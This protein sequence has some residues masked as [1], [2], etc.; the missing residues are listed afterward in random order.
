M[1][2]AKTTVKL[3]NEKG[4]VSI[5][6][7]SAVI[8]MITFIAF[9]VNIGI[10]VKAKI[11]LQ[12]AT[13][14]A[15]YAGASVQ[16]RQLTNIAYMNW[17]MRNVFK[18]WMFKY[19]VLGGL[20]L[21]SVHG[22]ESDTSMHFTMD[23]YT[24]TSSPAVDYYNFPSVCIDFAETG[25]IGMCTKYVVPG[26]PRFESSNVLGMD[27]TTNAF[28]DAIV[29]QKQLN[30]SQ[31]SNVNF[32]TASTWA[33]NVL[34]N[35]A[36]QRTLAQQAPQMATDAMGAF[37][38]AFELG[39]RIRSL[40]SEVNFPPVSNV[41]LNPAIGV[42][43][44]TPANSLEG[45]PSRERAL[46]AWQSAW[47]NL[48]S[49]GYAEGPNSDRTFKNSFT[50]TE[51]SPQPTQADAVAGSLSSILIPTG[52]RAN[53]KY[54]LDLQLTTLNYA[55]F[56]TSFASTKSD[57]NVTGAGTVD[58]EGQCDATK[59]G[60]P[61][62][63]YP[64]GFSKNPDLLTYYAVEGKSKFVG[65]FNPFS[66]EII[67]KATAAA[68]PF[69]GR[70]GPNLFDL[71]STSLVK[72]REAK[73]SSAYISAL[74]TSTFRGTYGGGG[75]GAYAPGMPIPINVGSG[76]QKFWMTGAGES[77]GGWIQGP[78]I[79][80]GIPNIVWD[81]PS[82]NIESN[83]NYLSTEDIQ[84]IANNNYGSGSE[85]DPSAGL[86]NK[87]MF[88]RF[89]QKLRNISS[90]VVSS[91][92]IHDAL[93]AVKA[94]TMYD[95]NNYMI[96]SPEGINKEVGTDSWGAITS[97]ITKTFNDNSQTYNV[98]QMELYAPLV[99]ADDPDAM[100]QEIGTAEA[101]LADYLL[102]QEAAVKKYR[103]S[104][105]LVAA[106]IF[107]SNISGETTQYTGQ[108]AANVISDLSVIQYQTIG[109]DSSTA[110]D[111]SMLPSCTSMNGKFLYFYTGNASLVRNYNS[112]DCATSL[113]D[114]LR[115][116]W[117]DQSLTGKNYI[118]N[119]V[120]GNSFKEA[121]FTAYRPGPL[122]GAG[123]ADGK[124]I[125]PLSGNSD[126]MIRN[127][128][129]TKFIPLN[130]VTNE[131]DAAYGMSKMVIYSEGSSN[132]VSLDV[133]RTSFKNY[134]NN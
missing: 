83:V 34:T 109:S 11:N 7:S 81:Y 33:Y 31:R 39:L 113:K 36:T 78:D 51:L 93:L 102:R 25:G 96:P 45:S 76:S 75:A 62:P 57:I 8:V 41:C 80:Y 124:Q 98:Y 59:V 105:N 119:F 12:N 6:L 73:K 49:N 37:P 128:Y 19:Y 74:R 61:I 60:L 24:R 108:A 104:M 32:L 92:E 116:R 133:K 43:C 30:C 35:D 38:K 100:I 126:T 66:S 95:V 58:T 79:F 10:F 77:I 68:K 110:Q 70:I 15:A 17:E 129:S 40:E 44:V 130:S 64:L 16:A 106:D 14:A 21:S 27:E 23:S 132:N 122:H 114:L 3:L 123:N 125:N 103:D 26:L 101:V 54:Y 22:S 63:G 71:K 4:Q 111:D 65:L 99:A 120:I 115:T 118:S 134:L 94:P 84:V 52:N 9:I 107:N 1:I 28:V 29:S 97:E 88:E 131:S 112:T 53:T 42:N 90:S 18:E 67:L 69:G 86:Y 91:D 47:R 20:N 121:L 82:G 13:D 85:L 2:K 48:G 72:T 55:T 87:S 89:K 56:Y 5:F 127:S 46:K 117:A 50:L